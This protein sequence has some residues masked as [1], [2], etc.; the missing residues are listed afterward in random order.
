MTNEYGSFVYSIASVQIAVLTSRGPGK[1]FVSSRLWPNRS[2]F[3]RDV[4]LHQ[5]SCPFVML[6]ECNALLRDY[7]AALLPGSVPNIDT[8]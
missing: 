3:K 5:L 6:F 4:F 7:R 8:M 2:S 1:G